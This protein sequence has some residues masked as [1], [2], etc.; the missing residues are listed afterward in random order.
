MK[1]N[2]RNSPFANP[3]YIKSLWIET[4]DKNNISCHYDKY[5]YDWIDGK[6]YSHPTYEGAMKMLNKRKLILGY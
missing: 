3:A 5:A 1:L 6:T 4:V 2:Y